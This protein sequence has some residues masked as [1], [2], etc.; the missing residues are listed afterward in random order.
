[1]DFVEKVKS[2]LGMKAAHRGF[3]AMGEAY[4]LRESGDAYGR[5]FGGETDFLRPENTISWNENVEAAD[6]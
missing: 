2:D 1:M 4:A 5:D 3:A 6:L